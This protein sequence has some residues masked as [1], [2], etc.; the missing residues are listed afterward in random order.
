MN[1]SD[2]RLRDANL[3]YV[4]YCTSDAHVG[5]AHGP[6]F[7]S[8]PYFVGG[9]H[10]NAVINAVWDTMLAKGMGSVPGTQA[11]FTGASAGARGALF[12]CDAVGA[13]VRASLSQVC[14]C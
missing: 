3:A 8:A 1:S 5:A 7:S 6:V 2:V 11:M 13:R 10:G 12:N 14:E 4:K 9:M